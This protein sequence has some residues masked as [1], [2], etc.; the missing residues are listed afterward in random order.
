MGDI[1]EGKLSDRRTL[2][3]YPPELRRGY[4]EIVPV[5]QPAAGANLIYPIGST[6]WERI[7]SIAITLTTSATQAFRSLAIA[8]A[9]NNGAVFNST[10]V[11]AGIPAS[12]Q[13]TVYGDLWGVSPVE[14]PAG[15]S[16]EGS[17]TS[18]AANAAIATTETLQP[19][20]YTATVQIEMSGTLTAG[21]DNN[22]TQL[23]LGGGQT[24][25]LD[26]GIQAGPQV[27]GPFDFEVTTAGTVKVSVGANAGTTGSIYSAQLTITPQ[28][29]QAGVQLPA[30]IMKSGWQLQV[31]MFTTQAADQLGPATIVTERYPS[32]FATGSLFDDEED[33]LRRVVRQLSYGG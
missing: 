30:F 9:D 15:A 1:T 13:F 25:P 32:D 29:V 10:L 5:A 12:Q 31:Q 17:L 23:V 20:L 14:T 26:N 3:A 24:Y 19:G 11:A 22:N 2:L 7:I 8:Y 28:T 27:F 6:W 18:P 4:T 16:A 33:Q 21:T